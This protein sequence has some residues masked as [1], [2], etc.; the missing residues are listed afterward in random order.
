[1]NFMHPHYYCYHCTN[2]ASVDAESDLM[3][4]EQLDTVCLSVISIHTSH[5]IDWMTGG[6][7]GCEWWTTNCLSAAEYIRKTMR[8]CTKLNVRS[9]IEHHFIHIFY[10][11]EIYWWFSARNF[12]SLRIDLKFLATYCNHSI[13]DSFILQ[14]IRMIFYSIHLILYISLATSYHFM[15]KSTKNTF[16]F[17]ILLLEF[18]V[19]FKQT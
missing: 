3:L 16:S 9:A 8:K 18:F 5:H 12:H 10:S 17:Q 14:S 7:G 6:H 19:V 13:W 15:H 2:I 11:I 1:M 4:M